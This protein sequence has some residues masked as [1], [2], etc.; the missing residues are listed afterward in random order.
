MVD[1]RV[2][3]NDPFNKNLIKLDLDK[4]VD[5]PPILRAHTGPGGRPAAVSGPSP[6]GA[7]VRVARTVTHCARC[8]RV[9]EHV[10]EGESTTPSTQHAL[11]P[12]TAQRTH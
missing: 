8:A 7:S 5:S 4:F 11:N 1:I 9:P 12:Q 2:P 10:R 3:L 6:G